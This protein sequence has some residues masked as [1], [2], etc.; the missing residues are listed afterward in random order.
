MEQNHSENSRR[1]A[2]NTVCLYFR[3]LIGMFVSL[4]TSRVVLNAL[5]VE[6]YGIYNVV[7]GFVAMFSLVSSALTSSIGRF[8]TY[9]LGTGDKQNLK[10]VFAT[11]L[12]IQLVL[13]ALIILLC[14]TVGLWFLHTKMTIPAERMGAAS[15][16]FQASVLSFVLNLLYCPYYGAIIAHEK[17]NIFAIFG[18]ISIIAK[19]GIALFIA[20]APFGFDRLVVY[21]FLILGITLL[22]ELVY[23]VYCY[24]H[25]EESRVMPYFHKATWKEMSGFAGWNAI[26]CTAGL[27]KDQGVN[28]LLNMFFGPV[29]NAARG[30]AISV[31]GAVGGMTNNFMT[32][33]NP[34]I[35][36]SYAAGDKSYCFMLVERGSRFGFYIS[37]FF[38]IPI[39]VEAPFILKLWLGEYP[40]FSVVFTRLTLVLSLI[41]VLSITLINL[42]LSVGKIRNYQIAVGLVLLLN[43]PLSYLSLKLGA[44]P[45]SVYVV[46]IVISAICLVVRLYFLKSMTGLDVR[47]YFTSVCSNVVLVTIISSLLPAIFY[48]TIEN[49]LLRF[50]S[51]GLA[52]VFS[53]SS[54]V[55]YI[56]CSES[57]RSFI[58]ERLGMVKKRLVGCFR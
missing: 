21:A 42:Q 47:R 18:I 27:L 37:L 34:Q 25:F 39:F 41:D 2:K 53:V 32:A 38:V 36:K 43:F 51:V 30:I 8:L 11:S 16:V 56:G 50:F 48:I 9:A 31:I 3:M 19:F 26:G 1:I 46:A 35:T 23:I 49:E 52:S 40:D 4:Y 13:S 17:M 28:V 5:G 6:D 33:L 44:P 22:M 10:D 15:I 29:V 7:G 12:L 20:Y 55:L 14:E 58:F 54:S 45:T 57:E 24:R